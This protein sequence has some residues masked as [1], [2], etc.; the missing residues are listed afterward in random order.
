V[1]LKND[2]QILPLKK[3]AVIAL[4][5]PPAKTSRIC[6]VVGSE[7]GNAITDVLFSN[8]IPSG[9]LTPSSTSAA[10]RAS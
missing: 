1:L 4:V 8:C 3:S 5:G 6:R 7:T 2:S 9:N 10:V